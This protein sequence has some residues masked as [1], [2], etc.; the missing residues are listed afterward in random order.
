LGTLGR[1]QN[2][3]LIGSARCDPINTRSQSVERANMNSDN[4]ELGIGRIVV[5]FLSKG[6]RRQ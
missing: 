3:N 5:P 6:G 4:F 1:T 2:P